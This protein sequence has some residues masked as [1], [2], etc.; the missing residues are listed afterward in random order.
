[1]AAP[2]R[3]RPIPLFEAQW[4][5]AALR[6]KKAAGERAFAMGFHLRAIADEDLSFPSFERCFSPGLKVQGLNRSGWFVSTGVDP[7]GPKR[8]GNAIVTIGV[9]PGRRRRYPLDIRYG[10]WKSTQLAEQLAMVNRIF[11]PAVIMVETNAYQTALVDWAK[12]SAG[13]GN[14]YWMKL[15]PTVTGANKASLEIGLPVLEVEFSNEGWR[16][17][18]GEYEDHPGD[19]SCGWCEWDKQIRYHP[20]AAETDLVMATWFARQGIAEWADVA[21]P[22]VT[23]LAD[24]SVR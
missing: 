22:R 17:P 13:E 19:C 23:D 16:V 11:Q 1:M 15:E 9:E 10:A 2:I 4:N 6:A 20:I 12:Q 21:G 8:R 14:D 24:L 7:A 5:Q 18:R 3:L